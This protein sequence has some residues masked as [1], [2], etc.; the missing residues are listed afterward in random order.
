[1][2]VVC[3][4]ARDFIDGL[5]AESVALSVWSP[6]YFVGKEYE[7]H[8]T[9]ESWQELV[10]GAIGRHFRALKPGGFMAVNIADILAFPD[11]SLPRF[12]AAVVS[13]QRSPI[14]RDDVLRASAENPKANRR[15]LAAILGC[16]EQTVQRR[17]EGNN[18]RGGKYGVQ[19]RVYLVA[20]MIEEAIR[21]AGLVL[22]DR[23][24][25]VKDPAWANSRWS[26]VSYRAVDEFEYVYIAWKPGPTLVN[27]ARLEPGE[28]GS[29]GSRAVWNIRSVRANDDHEAKFPIELPRRLIRM[30]SEPG[31]LVI[32]PFVGSGT[33]GIAALAEGR[34]FRGS[35]LDPGYAAA[36]ADALS[37][38]HDTGG[39]SG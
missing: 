30:L 33:T 37:Q 4:D 5:D 28:W 36:A 35:D 31:D 6:P 1:V 18:I 8:L 38:D 12:Q 19:T 32:D 23:R 22:Y 3:A 21:D 7:R 27:R 26:A 20:G 29:W 16:S 34:T 9:F 14:T 39:A 10:A 11:P 25:W 2:T 24:V 17:L 15:E 13:G